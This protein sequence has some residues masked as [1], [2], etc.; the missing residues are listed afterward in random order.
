MEQHTAVAVEGEKVEREEAVK[1]LQG[2][3]GRL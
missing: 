3:G 2:S 1:P